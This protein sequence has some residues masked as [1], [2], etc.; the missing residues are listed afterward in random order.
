MDVQI[1]QAT[2]DPVSR[3]GETTRQLEA[4]YVFRE[5]LTS[6]SGVGGQWKGS[7]L[8]IAWVIVI[9]GHEVRIGTDDYDISV[10][11]LLS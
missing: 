5:I 4:R 3:R 2:D 7:K 8:D 9:Q 1:I 6:I 10:I 11:A